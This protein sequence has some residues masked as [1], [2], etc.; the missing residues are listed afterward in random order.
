MNIEEFA[1]KFIKAEDEAWR[2]GNFDPLQAMEDPNV[3]I[4]IP[5]FP[6]MVGWEAHKQLIQGTVKVVSGLRQ[7]FKYLAGDGN[8]FALTYKSS[9]RLTSELPGFPVPKGKEYSTD[10]LCLFQLNG[11][12]VAE[13]WM[14]GSITVVD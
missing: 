4:R 12:K 1:Q 10:Y 13:A 5:P 14:N 6:D 9:G 11:G 8:L 7:E 2:K 3:V